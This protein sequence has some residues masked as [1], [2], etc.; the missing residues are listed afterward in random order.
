MDRR[1]GA[2]LFGL[3]A[4]AAIAACNQPVNSHVDWPPGSDWDAMPHGDASECDAACAV[5]EKLGCPE[6]KATP[7]GASCLDVCAANAGRLDTSCV[8]KATSA[9][10][11]RTCHVKCKQ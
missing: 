7:A 11:V 3:I 4:L 10:T 2:A 9:E 5:L 8:A 6:S 1:H